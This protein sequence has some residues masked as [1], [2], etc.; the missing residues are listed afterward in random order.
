MSR[1]KFIAIVAL[2]AG[3]SMILG[4]K[5]EAQPEAQPAT[6][7]VGSSTTAPA[8]GSTKTDNGST[9]TG[10]SSERRQNE[11]WT[12]ANGV[13][14]LGNV[15][16][17]VF[18]DRPLEIARDQT[19]LGGTEPQTDPTPATVGTSGTGMTPPVKTDPPPTEQP[20]AAASSSWDELIPIETLKTEI[21]NVRNFM[22]TSVQ[23]YSEYKKATLMIPGKM[24]SVAVLSTIAMEHGEEIGWKADAPYIRNLAKKINEDTL[25]P[26]KKDFEKVQLLFEGIVGILDRSPPPDLEEPDPED[27]YADVASMDLVMVRIDEAEKRMKNEAGTESAFESKKDLIRHEAAILGTM[28]HVLTM[29]SYGYA[30]DEE[31]VGYARTLIEACKTINNATETN[32]FGSYDLALSKIST[33][34]S[35]C[36]SNYKNN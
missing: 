17:D 34:C 21:K 19:P 36:H 25:Q 28:S 30:D 32:D 29:E 31:F 4:C 13:E 23:R 22:N 27:S 16:L 8:G 9:T 15:P 35:A 7:A 18:F 26:V 1:S 6:G 20:V 14:Y 12:D 11:R 2:Y 24:A 33:T 5:D 3:S 10:A